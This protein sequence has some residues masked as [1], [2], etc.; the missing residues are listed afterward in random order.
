M[1]TTTTTSKLSALA[2]AGF[3]SL[4]GIVSIVSPTQAQ[5]AE[6][7]TSA[8]KASD[9]KCEGVKINA[10]LVIDN[11]GSIINSDRKEEVSR[12]YKNFINVAKEI[13]KDAKITLFPMITPVSF[14]SK[15]FSLSN[16]DDWEALSYFIGN[17]DFDS[18]KHGPD[19]WV[20]EDIFESGE[21]VSG[22][23]ESTFSN[24][25]KPVKRAEVVNEKKK[26]NFNM[27]LTISDD[28]V[29][30][31]GEFR[32]KQDT[33]RDIG[34]NLRKKG[35]STKSIII[36]DIKNPKEYPVQNPISAMTAN[37]P[38]LNKDYFVG[39][40]TKLKES[41]DSSLRVY[42][43]ENKP[44][45]KPS[46]KPSPKPTSETPTST[47]TTP[48]TTPSTSEEPI[49]EPTVEPTTTPE[50]STPTVVE[51]VENTSTETVTETNNNTST[52]TQQV[53]ETEKE[54]ATNTE[55]VN[56]TQT[57]KKAP[58]TAVETTKETQVVDNPV[59]VLQPAQQTPQPVYGPKV[60]TGGEVKVPFLDK[61]KSFILG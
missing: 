43:E 34:I 15:S 13:D 16:K 27:F 28:E 56:N 17:F 58:Q 47:S 20:K 26:K 35:V 37:N 14:Y 29:I 42:C 41:L 1:S 49:P 5:A 44:K 50:V 48:K 31:D 52:Q 25:Y 46:P 10:A 61:V 53:V 9:L 40:I 33:L 45:T 57:V 38:K 11:S 8:T 2:L 59:P 22:E 60:H 55:T 39:D 36:N 24:L 19:N 3:V 7:S 6:S 51:T 18:S 21:L 32:G 30:V 54:T 23:W 12:A 4:S